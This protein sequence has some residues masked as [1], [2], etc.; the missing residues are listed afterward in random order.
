MKPSIVNLFQQRGIEV[1]KVSRDVE[2]KNRELNL[3]TQIDLY[4]LPFIAATR[5]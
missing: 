5:R 4:V 3:A 2:A 1:H